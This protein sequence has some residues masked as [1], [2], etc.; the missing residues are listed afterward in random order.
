MKNLVVDTNQ[1]IAI[2]I[3][4]GKP[5]NILLIQELELVAPIL[6]FD[7]LQ[8]NIRIIHKKSSLE[9]EEIERFIQILKK[10]IKIIPEKK[11]L[12]FRKEAKQICPDKKDIEYFA[13]AIYMNCP[14]WSNDKKLKNQNK[15]K[16]Y[17]TH[18]LID[19]LNNE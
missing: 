18:E 10:R 6:L 2:L 13:L 3:K 17:S 1:I 16:I 5:L 15:I 8:R 4:Q 14:I 12:K 19:V 7:E 11:F 9:Q